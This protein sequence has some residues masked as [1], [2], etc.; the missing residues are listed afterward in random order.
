[1]SLCALMSTLNKATDNRPF[2]CAHAVR[3][4]VYSINS[5]LT[6]HSITFL[7]GDKLLFCQMLRGNSSVTLLQ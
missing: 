6:N 2:I 1:M 5:P 3:S 7:S 4:S